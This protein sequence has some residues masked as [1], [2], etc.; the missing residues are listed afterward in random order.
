MYENEEMAD[1]F[2][3]MSW[4]DWLSFVKEQRTDRGRE[5]MENA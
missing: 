4:P 3:D 1:F 2:G 5:L